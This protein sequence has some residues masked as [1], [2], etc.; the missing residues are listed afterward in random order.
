MRPRAHRWQASPPGYAHG[1]PAEHRRDDQRLV[2]AHDE[3]LC[4]AQDAVGNAVHVGREGLGHD[5][6]S[7]APTATH[8][9]SHQDMTQLCVG[10]MS[11]T[12]LN[13]PARQSSSAP[14]GAG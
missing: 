13:G 2:P 6:N 5:R 11:V 1:L 14:R 9:M 12:S 10:E 3:V 8:E 4:H 7:H